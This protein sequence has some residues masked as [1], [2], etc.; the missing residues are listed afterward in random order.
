MD[1]STRTTSFLDANL[2]PEPQKHRRVVTILWG[3][4]ILGIVAVLPYSLTLQRDVL[5][6]G[7]LPLP[8][9]VIAILELVI[10]SAIL[11]LVVMAGLRMAEDLG[12]GAPVLSDWL[13]GKPWK[14]DNSLDLLFTVLIGLAVCAMVA[15]L[16]A[17]IF[18]PLMKA[19][20]PSLPKIVTPPMWEGLLSSLYGGLTEEILL[21][22][23]IMTLFAWLISKLLLNQ[24]GPPSSWIMWTANL[25]SSLLYSLVLIP[26]TLALGFHF[27]EIYLTRVL[28]LN[29]L[30]GIIFGW[31]Y[32]KRGIESAIVAHLS[33]DILLQALF[34]LLMP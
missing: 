32:W 11:F 29:T 24:E 19:T 17:M 14:Q 18:L 33:G 28:L 23:F 6:A 13:A 5:H 25:G 30:P 26:G 8:L 22:L 4:S 20:G 12:L 2:V 16:D 3:L 9:P 7:S 27:N 15:F 10:Q 34:P 21:R 31:L 1:S